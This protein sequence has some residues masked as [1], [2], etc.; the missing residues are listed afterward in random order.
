MRTQ[1][2]IADMTAG[3]KAWR[4]WTMLGWN[5]IKQRYRRT[6]IGPFWITISMSIMILAIGVIYAAIF[7]SALSTYLIY[8]AAG[9]VIWFFVSSTI[10]EGTSAFVAA[11]GIIK[12]SPIPLTIYIYRV[13]WRNIIILMH[14][15]IVVIVLFPFVRT[16]SPSLSGILALAAGL[17]IVVGN[18]FVICL[19]LALLST[20]FRDLPPIITSLMQVLFYVTPVLYEPSQLP[21]R[22]QLIAHYNP[23]YHVIDV[24]RR[25]MIGDLAD[26]ESYAVA[27]GTCVI[28]GAA[29]FLLFRRFRA[30]VPY[31]L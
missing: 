25:P 13:L 20:R 30:R 9:M 22:L 12:Q 11:E 5:D 1:A 4:F 8:L 27:I 7:Q 3:A 19:I 16:F 10:L 15:V 28:G 24:L 29:A 6:V 26:P 2:A 31:W 14:N 21:K 18:L 17:T 23:F